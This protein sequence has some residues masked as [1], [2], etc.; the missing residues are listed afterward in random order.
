[1]DN[2]MDKL[3]QRCS[4]QEIIRANAQA[5]AKETGRLREQIQGYDECMQE[6]RMLNLKNVESAEQLRAL[7]EQVKQLAGQTMAR[8]EETERQDHA[9]AERIHAVCETLNGISG[10]V[11]ALQEELQ[12]VRGDIGALPEALQTLRGDI[13]ALPEALQTLR[14]DIGTVPET[15]ETL[16]EEIRTVLQEEREV[17]K[18]MAAAW[19]EAKTALEQIKEMLAQGNEAVLS[20]AEKEK[21]VNKELEDY[22]HRESVK[23]YRNVQAVLVEELKNQTKEPDGKLVQGKTGRKGLYGLVI[24]TLLASLA[25][26]G[27]LAAQLLG[28]I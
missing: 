17:R 20:H 8:M 19:E 23:V 9:Q 14:E 15:L 18:G 11:E 22:M 16:R 26:L 7:A 5:E 10:N 21:A 3:S 27:I 12:A 28:Y 1:M 6:M 13:G 24:V 2:Y 4:A 25:N